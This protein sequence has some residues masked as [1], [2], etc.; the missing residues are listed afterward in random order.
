MKIPFEE[1]EFPGNPETPFVFLGK[2][3]YGPWVSPS[4]VIPMTYLS[5]CPIR[6]SKTAHKMNP[7]KHSQES[8]WMTNFNRAIGFH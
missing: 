6:S 3:A 8:Q 7:E 4:K 5:A 2:C 1:M